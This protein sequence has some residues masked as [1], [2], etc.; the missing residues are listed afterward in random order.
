MKIL[1]IE[2]EGNL[3]ISI[4]I[5]LT[6]KHFV[7]E[8]VKNMNDAIDKI[9]IYE[10]DFIILDLMLPNGNGFKILKEFEKQ[11]KLS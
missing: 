9:L 1:L 6:D 2:D 8:H 4:Q 10:Y 7:C 3:A 11:K 5:Y